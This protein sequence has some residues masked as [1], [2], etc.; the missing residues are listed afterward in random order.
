MPLRH[1]AATAGDV[2]LDPD[3]GVSRC[4]CGALRVK[5]GA[6]Q[7]ELSETQFQRLQ[8]L[9]RLADRHFGL[10]TGPARPATGPHGSH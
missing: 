1:D 8:Q 9:L 2:G 3:W 10:S 6:V 7:L 4:A 5:L